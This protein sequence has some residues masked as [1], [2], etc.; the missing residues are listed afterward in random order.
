MKDH[1]D[2]ST[3]NLIDAANGW[4]KCHRDEPVTQPFDLLAGQLIQA[5]QSCEELLPAKLAVIF[6]PPV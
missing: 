1:P 4:K 3:V 5:Y 2:A 6:R